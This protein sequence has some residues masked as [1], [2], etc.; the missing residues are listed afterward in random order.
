MLTDDTVCLLFDSE[1]KLHL[2]LR[3]AGVNEVVITPGS[4]FSPQCPGYGINQSRL[5]VAVITAD[6]GGMDAGK[7]E[8]WHIIPIGHEITNG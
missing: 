8:W 3:L 5:T 2:H 6:S 1:V 7:M 4:G